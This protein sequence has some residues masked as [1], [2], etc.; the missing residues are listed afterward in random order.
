M[1][2][3]WLGVEIRHLVA[4]A[5]VAREGSFRGAADRLGYVQSAV[6]QQISQLESLVG[7]RLLERSRGMK[8]CAP[9][10]AGE[11]LLEHV[12]QIVARYQAAQADMAALE[13]VDGGVLRVGMVGSVALRLLP[14]VVRRLA[15]AAP[16]VRLVPTEASAETEL[17]TLVEDGA[18]DAAFGVLPLEPG[19]FAGREL[20]AEPLALVVQADSPLAR[21]V[22]P[23]SV[24]DIA[25]LPLIGVQ[26]ARPQAGVEAWLVALG[27]TPRFVHLADTEAMAQAL[28]AAGLG[29]AILPRFALDQHDPR[30]AIVDLDESAPTCRLAA[31]WH[32]ERHPVAA[33]ASFCT[34]AGAAAKELAVVTDDIAALPLAHAA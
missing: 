33:L 20:V 4:L 15:D 29:V 14:G 30:T 19:P 13:R 5:A 1:T 24:D 2:G 31:F 8:G 32:R 17:F 22:E 6:S 12:D 23:P 26:S 7:C 28:V 16:A 21:A 27:T 11:V 9:T 10:A 18:I 3:E 25:R 34:A